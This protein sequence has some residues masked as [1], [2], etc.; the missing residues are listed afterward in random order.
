LR[1]HLRRLEDHTGSGG[2]LKAQHLIEELVLAWL[3]RSIERPRGRPLMRSRDRAMRL[4][5]ERM[6]QADW[7]NLSPSLL[8]E[9][10]GVGERTLQ[11]AFRERFALTPAAFLKARRL[12]AV[13]ERLLKAHE[14]EEKVGDV[15]AA[16]GF[17]HAGH[18]AAD[19]RRA[20]GETPSETLN[21]SQRA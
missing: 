13:R 11:Y 2:Y 14:G 12:S 9:V 19:Y 1:Q 21:R 7:D 18:F 8:C 10:G 3:D 5:L 15:S 4:C 17:W 16:F 6:A 20:F